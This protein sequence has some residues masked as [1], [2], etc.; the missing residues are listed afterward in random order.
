M[1]A[2]PGQA[3]R[4]PSPSAA[5]AENPVW[6]PRLWRVSPGLPGPRAISLRLSGWLAK[7]LT[8][9][10]H[11][12]GPRHPT[13]AATC[14]RL[15]QMTTRRRIQPRWP[16]VRELL[17]SPDPRMTRL[18]DPFLDK[19]GRRPG[20][21]ARGERSAGSIEQAGAAPSELV[22]DHRGQ[23]RFGDFVLRPGSDGV[24]VDEEPDR[25][26]AGSA[27]HGDES[28]VEGRLGDEGPERDRHGAQG[29]EHQG[30][31]GDLA[32]ADHGR[33]ERDGS[34]EER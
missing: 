27:G 3:T 21:A 15:T 28:E 13:K 12:P 16:R 23:Q 18:D 1:S 26:P 33:D 9:G 31:D 29:V 4:A 11:P 10:R 14:A 32:G 5:T 2:A 20:V 24:G 30:C 6:S 25:E 8:S 34:E 7:P 22:P 17:G 19:A